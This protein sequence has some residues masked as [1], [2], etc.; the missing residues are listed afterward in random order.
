MRLLSGI[1]LAAI[2][3]LLACASPARSETAPAAAPAA[4]APA[5]AIAI[6]ASNWKF[7]P[8]VI[9]VHVGEATTLHLTSDAGVHGIASKE[10]GIAQTALIPGKSV[11]VTF[12]PTRAG[13]YVLHCSIMCGP[14][15]DDMTLTVK[16]LA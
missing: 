13:T 4:A 8:A 9:T 1:S 10:L 2:V 11:D 3:A 14:G 6:A 16:V 5:A 7:T 15:H 12:T